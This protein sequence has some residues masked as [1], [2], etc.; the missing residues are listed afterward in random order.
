VCCM[1][2]SFAAP[3]VDDL[4]GPALRAAALEVVWAR[5]RHHDVIA[6]PVSAE[7][8]AWL[9]SA[10]LMLLGMVINALLGRDW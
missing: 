1:L 5:R 6:R 7:A 8:V 3:D 4:P 9:Q 10:L 2:A